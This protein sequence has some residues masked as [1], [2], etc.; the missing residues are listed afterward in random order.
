MLCTCVDEVVGTQRNQSPE[1][2]SSQYPDVTKTSHDKLL[3][4]GTRVL[5]MSY[6]RVEYT[7]NNTNPTGYSQRRTIS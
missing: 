2:L 5:Y 1:S 7:W 4:L 3:T 6:Q